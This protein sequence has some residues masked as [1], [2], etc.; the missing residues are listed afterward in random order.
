M[1]ITLAAT[2][3]RARCVAWSSSPVGPKRSTAAPRAASGRTESVW[4]MRANQTYG[5]AVPVAINGVTILRRNHEPMRPK[6]NADP[7]GSAW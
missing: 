3:E 7:R 6:E 4:C 1:A 5:A 2:A